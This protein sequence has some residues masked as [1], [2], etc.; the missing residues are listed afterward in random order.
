MR[1]GVLRY[2]LPAEAPIPWVALD[3]VADHIVAALTDDEPGPVLVAGPQALTGPEVAATLASAQGRPLRWQTIDPVQ[4]AD[5]LRPHTGD[6]IADGIAELYST[7]GGPPPA[8]DPKLLRCG[9]IT[10]DSWARTQAWDQDK[11][12]AA[13]H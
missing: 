11:A 2:P 7:T 13:A 6:E 9:R 5:L 4:Y 3:D 1:E 12:P 10:L 8:P